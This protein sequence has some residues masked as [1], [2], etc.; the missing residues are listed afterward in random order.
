M[1]YRM[2]CKFTEF[3]GALNHGFFRSAVQ[4]SITIFFADTKK[5][6]HYNLG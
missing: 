5:D 3:L 4:L 1:K 2:G 6:F